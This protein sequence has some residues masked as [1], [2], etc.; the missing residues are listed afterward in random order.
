MTFTERHLLQENYGEGNRMKYLKG[1]LAGAGLAAASHIMGMGDDSGDNSGSTHL[2]DMRTAHDEGHLW[3]S[4]L[5]K[6]QDAL[7]FFKGSGN[8]GGTT[9]DPNQSQTPTGVKDYHPSGA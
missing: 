2:D 1:G 7:G 3:N 4:T 6:G 9:P 5:Q 8:T